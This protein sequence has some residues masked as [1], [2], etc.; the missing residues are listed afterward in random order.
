M[1]SN[2]K[3]YVCPKSVF[4]TISNPNL[5]CAW[6]LPRGEWGSLCSDRCGDWGLQLRGGAP[7]DE[8][9]CLRWMD[10][11]YGLNIWD[12]YRIASTSRW[13]TCGWEHLS[14]LDGWW[15]DIGLAFGWL[16]IWGG[17]W[18]GFWMDGWIYGKC[19]WMVEYL[20]RALR[21]IGWMFG[22]TGWIYGLDI[23]KVVG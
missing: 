2:P 15:L 4:T 22:Y 3:S 5:F 16:D 10:G 14:L 11:Y 17:Y 19:C 23:G 1:I 8:N 20:D 7:A 21:Y 9:I 18:M 12:G 6:F 13:R